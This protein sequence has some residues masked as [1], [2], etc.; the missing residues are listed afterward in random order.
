MRE[1]YKIVFP[2]GFFSNIFIIRYTSSTLHPSIPLINYALPL[3]YL[4]LPFKLPSKSV[5]LYSD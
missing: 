4:S 3:Y 1:T 2:Y 5:F